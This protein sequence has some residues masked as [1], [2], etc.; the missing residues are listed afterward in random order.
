MAKNFALQWLPGFV[1]PLT[2]SQQPHDGRICGIHVG[3][4]EVTNNKQEI[5]R[6]A[7]QRGL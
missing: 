7:A 6:S 3:H 2:Y 5:Q 1:V 4:I